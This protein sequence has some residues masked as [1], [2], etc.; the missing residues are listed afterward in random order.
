[1]VGTHRAVSTRVAVRGIEPHR[2]FRVRVKGLKRG[3]E[4]D[5]RVLRKGEQGFEARTRARKTK[6]QPDRF[7]VF[8]DCG[9]GTPESREVAFQAYPAKP[10]FVVLPGDIM[11]SLGRISE[12]R[13]KVFP[14][15]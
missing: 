1:V 14:R 5:Y 8:G 3:E 12:Y 11:Y 13:T 7:V 9:A 4:F 15:L 6:D 2:V 10:D